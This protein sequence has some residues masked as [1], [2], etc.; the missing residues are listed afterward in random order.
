M[1]KL[2]R[3]V[4]YLKLLS[5]SEAVSFA[6]SKIVAVK[7]PRYR[8]YAELLRGKAGIEIGGPSECF[9]RDGVLPIYPVIASLDG[10][11]FSTSTIWEGR[12]S[13]GANFLYD[14]AKPPGHQHIRDAVA[15]ENIGSEQYDFLVA[16]NAL[17]HVANPLRAL[18]EWLRVVKPG[19][20]LFLVLPNKKLN[21]DHK[22]EVTNFTHLIE[23]FDRLT[24]EDDLTHL[25]EVLASHDLT[26]DPEAGT[27]R[28]FGERSR[29]NRENRAL[30][31]HVFDLPLLTRIFEYFSLDVLL[32][33][34]TLT[35]HYILGRKKLSPP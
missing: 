10:V 27:L 18:T 23:D 15:L 29:R 12:L 34:T 7:V 26:L 30:H 32:A 22:R 11:N 14:P 16:C 24:G 5:A 17:E 19:G 9:R 25:E 13:E 1:G 3:L 35:D 20:L 8:E 28:E 21:F 6:V 4:T 33:S 31:H 2:A